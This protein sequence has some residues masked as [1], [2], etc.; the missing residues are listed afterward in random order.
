ME[1]KVN[2]SGDG[3]GP[4]PEDPL[5]SGHVPITVAVQEAVEGGSPFP[6]TVTFDHGD[7]APT[8]VTITVTQSPAGPPSYFS[9]PATVQ[10]PAGASYVTFMISTFMPPAS[11][12]VEVS[13]SDGTVTVRSG[14]IQV[15]QAEF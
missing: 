11:V 8:T 15:Y 12:S 5:T 7:P 2:R 4:A 6:C 3:V 14:A 1:D 10:L 13:A 9:A